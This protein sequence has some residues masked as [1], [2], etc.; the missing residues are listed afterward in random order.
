MREKGREGRGAEGPRD[1]DVLVLRESEGGTR[2][3][4]DGEVS[5]GGSLS[6]SE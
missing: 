5:K 2:R 4:G 1:D 6:F 3:F